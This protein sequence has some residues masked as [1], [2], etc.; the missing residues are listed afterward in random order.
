M[1][2]KEVLCRERVRFL[3]KIS[4]V[5]VL[6]VVQ[7]VK[8]GTVVRR[9]APVRQKNSREVAKS[10]SFLG[11]TDEHRITRIFLRKDFLFFNSLRFSVLRD[12]S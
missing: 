9:R 2:R 10:Q 1:F 4:C 11:T 12:V 8:R 3:L 7:K 5:S 6:S